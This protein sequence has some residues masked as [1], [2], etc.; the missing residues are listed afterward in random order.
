MR[1]ENP[2][3]VGP[4]NSAPPV[5]EGSLGDMISKNFSFGETKMAQE[6]LIFESAIFHV[7]VVILL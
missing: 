2:A 4:P 5:V 3:E 7:I 1:I 6:Y